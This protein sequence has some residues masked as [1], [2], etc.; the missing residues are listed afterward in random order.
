MKMVTLDMGGYVS[1]PPSIVDRIFRNFFVSNYSQT[2]VHYGKIQSLPW[3]IARYAED[4]YGM[5][6]AIKHALQTMFEGFFERVDVDVHIDPT[7]GKDSIDH[8]IQVDVTVYKNSIAYSA[9]KL[10]S[11]VKTRISKIED[12]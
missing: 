5:E 4:M 6:L 9:G 2:N 1:D 7:D 11:L 12:V 3:I 10:L 8:T